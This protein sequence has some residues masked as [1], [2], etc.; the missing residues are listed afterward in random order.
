MTCGTTEPSW[1]CSTTT[2]WVL[3]FILKKLYNNCLASGE[4]VFDNIVVWFLIFYYF[5][6]NRRKLL[7]ICRF[8]G[9]IGST[10]IWTIKQLTDGSGHLR[11]SRES[12]VSFRK[13]TPVHQPWLACNIYSTSK[14]ILSFIFSLSLSLSF[15]DSLI[16]SLND[17]LFL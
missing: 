3:F 8:A 14:K 1:S 5:P 16:I 13:P 17:K 7:T 10:P 6:F 15:V 11:Q 9:V 12:T 4:K 2:K